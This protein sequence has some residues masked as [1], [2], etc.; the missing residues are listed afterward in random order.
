LTA[1]AAILAC[2]VLGLGCRDI[3][4]IQPITYSDAGS[5]G[6]NGATPSTVFTGVAT[7]DALSVQ[8]GFVYAE[9]SAS[10]VDRCATTGCTA[11]THVITVPASLTYDSFALGPSLIDYTVSGPITADGGASGELRTIGF[12]GTGE[13]TVL[14]GLADP[15][16]LATSGAR[17]FWVDDL[18]DDTGGDDTVYCVG[19]N[20][21]PNTPWITMLS[22]GAYGLVADSSD[23][24]LLADD[25]SL[26]NLS[27]LACS[28]TTACNATPRTVITPLDYATVIQ[29]VASDG[30]Y[31]YVAREDHADVVRVDATGQ[32]K[33][34]VTS[35]DV[36]AIAIDAAAGYLY[37]ATSTGVLGK[38]KSDGSGQPTTLACTD[39]NVAA[40]A[41]DD[42]NLYFITG[43]AGSQILSI[44][45]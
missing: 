9:V 32:V 36:V 34:V 11:P 2:A 20:G 44:P 37:Y 15:L 12:D 18:Y 28:V 24:Y 10:G 6:C 45:K 8:N 4:G 35:L 29:Q 39:P 16:Y 31:A 7:Y 40:L 42:S 21:Q 3:A 22:R 43:V 38:A 5:S 17:T 26:N 14:G 33:Q 13:T 25:V 19:C 27:L 30:T 1:R 41:L 23:V